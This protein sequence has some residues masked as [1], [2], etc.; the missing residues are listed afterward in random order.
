MSWLRS[1]RTVR[2]YL[3]E[4]DLRVERFVAAAEFQIL[5][6]FDDQ[7]RNRGELALPVGC[8]IAGF[9]EGDPYQACA[10]EYD[11]GWLGRYRTVR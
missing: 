9:G 8:R 7:G 10:D 11:A 3:Y 5:D 6:V 2:G 4:G 1:L